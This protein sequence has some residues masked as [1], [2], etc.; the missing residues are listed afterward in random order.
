M[1]LVSNEI[2]LTSKEFSYGRSK[3][4]V[5]PKLFFEGYRLPKSFCIEAHARTDRR[6]DYLEERGPALGVHLKGC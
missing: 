4:L 1:Y 3:F 5:D 2:L 6:V